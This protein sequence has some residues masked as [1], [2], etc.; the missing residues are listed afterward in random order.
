M[1]AKKKPQKPPSQPSRYGILHGNRVVKLDIR[2][3]VYNVRL[4]SG[5][6]NIRDKQG[7]VHQ[8]VEQFG[9]S[10]G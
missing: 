8:T 3:L 5:G 4:R 9:H 10:S 6:N 7:S 1:Q 2:V